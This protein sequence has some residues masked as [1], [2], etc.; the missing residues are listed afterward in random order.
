MQVFEA[1]PVD[2]IWNVLSDSMSCGA[3]SRCGAGHSRASRIDWSK[4][5][6][7]VGCGT[8]PFVGGCGV[9]NIDPTETRRRT[10]N[11]YNKKPQIPLGGSPRSVVICDVPIIEKCIN[12]H[13]LPRVVVGSYVICAPYQTSYW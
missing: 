7:G 4:I 12:L 9:G 5:E 11:K 10:E 8:G 1:D 2:T 6:A 3:I 13:R